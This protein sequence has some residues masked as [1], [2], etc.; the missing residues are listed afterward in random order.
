MRAALVQ[1]CGSDDPQA[2][3]AQTQALIATGAAEGAKLV[4]TPENTN[5]ISADRAW[6]RQVI[7]TEAEDPTLAALR[8]Q[9]AELG[10]WLLIGSLLLKPGDPDEDRFVNRSLLIAP[11]GQIAARYDKIHMFD[12]RPRK[13][14]VYRE[15][16][17]VR[18]GSRAVL[19]QEPLPMGL[20][21]CYDLRFPRLYRRLAQAGAQVLTIPAAFT[22][23]TGEA[24]WEVLLRARAIETGCYVLAPAQCGTHGVT[25]PSKRG[26]RRSWGHSLVVAPWGEVLADGGSEPGV[27]SVD[28]DLAQV[29]EARRRIGS[30][31]GDRDFSGP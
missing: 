2:N 6:Q 22:V 9:A 20:T 26:P 29:R 4:L 12:A 7:R 5:I 8:L 3:L 11:D 17:A 14:E 1:L 19:V 10:I 21:I 23:P 27:V 15:S 31:A 28:I 24:H 18:P 16:A 13:G 25:Q 30:L